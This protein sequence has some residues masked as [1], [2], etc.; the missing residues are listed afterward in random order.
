MAIDKLVPRYLNK[1]DDVRLVKNVE[2]TDALNVRIAADTDGDGGV[3]K[4]AYGNEGVAFKAGNNWQAKPHALPDG[5]NKVVGDVADLKD[6]LVV[7][8][9]WNSN[10]DHSIYRFSTAAGVAEL[11]YRDSVLS[12]QAD[13]FIKG[14]VI[15]NLDND[16]LLY[17]TDGISSPKKI[18]VSRAI[19]GGYSG[20]LNTGSNSE[21]LEFITLAK[22]PPLDPPT[23]SFYTDSTVEENNIYESTYQFAYRY[24]YLDG[25][26][27]AI[28]KYSE[29]AVSQQQLRDGIITD[30][31]KLVNNAIRVSV[32]TSVADVKRIEVLA[33]NGN[34]GA[35]FIID[36]IANP[37][38]TS[39]PLKIL[40]V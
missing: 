21:K 31:Q 14:D 11:V 26:V 13:S 20:V 2:M 28:S 10:G 25:E 15:R 22:K 4:N 37:S 12:F 24:V 35:W 6:G 34:T 36:D 18:N 7:F 32:V 33:R 16:A 3:V 19:R 40:V 9:V 38:L 30:E 39:S 1:E 27:S 29:L 17:F 5:T 8:F 23:F